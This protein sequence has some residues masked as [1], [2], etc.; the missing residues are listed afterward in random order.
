MGTREDTAP[1]HVE[2]ELAA[3]IH[4]CILSVMVPR[5]GKLCRLVRQLQESACIGS[6]QAYYVVRPTRV[7]SH[8]RLAHAHEITTV[9]SPVWQCLLHQADTST[10]ILC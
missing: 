1:W 5:P 10:I 7:T 2:I 9:L 3:H 4:F 8:G 6:S